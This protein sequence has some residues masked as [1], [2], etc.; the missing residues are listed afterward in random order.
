VTIWEWPKIEGAI[1]AHSPRRAAQT[2]ARAAV[3][4]VMRDGAGG[5]EAL[6]IHRADHPQDPW[7]GHMAFPGGRWEPQ[8]EDLRATAVRETREELGLDLE[9]D[10]RR[11]GELDELE[12][13]S[14]PRGRDWTIAPFVY[15]LDREAPLRLS[16]EVRSAHWIDLSALFAK[17][18]QSRLL[19]LHE[20]REQPFPC[21]RLDQR[22]IWGLT[23]RM[24]RNFETIVRAAAGN[25]AER[26]EN[27]ER[28][29]S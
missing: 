1:A 3:A 18:N 25:T 4:M 21:I 13:V 10:G 9:R 22:V 23:Y 20:G 12:T 6:L 24:L 11:L 16:D 26:E 28:T 5:I 8:D 29:G 2:V 17:E 19:F 27:P 7:S 15:R 14:R